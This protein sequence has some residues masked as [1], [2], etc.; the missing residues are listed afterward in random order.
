MPVDSAKT[1]SPSNGVCA[2]R[3]ARAS[4]SCAMIAQAAAAALVERGV[5]GDHCNRR[6]GAGRRRRRSRNSLPGRAEHRGPPAAAS[7]SP[8]SARSAAQKRPQSG[9][10]VAPQLLTATIA[11]TVCA[12]GEAQR[13]AADAALEPARRGAE[14]R[15]GIAQREILGRRARRRAAEAR[16]RAARR[17]SGRRPGKPRSNRIAAGTIGTTIGG[18]PG[19]VDPEPAARLGEPVH[20]TAGGVEAKGRAAGQHDR[21]DPVD[22]GLRG[23]QFGLAAARR[24]AAHIDRGRPPS[25]SAST[26]VV[27]VMPS[28]SSACPTR[29]PGTSVIRL[30]GPVAAI[31]LSPAAL[32]GC[33]IGS[34]K[35]RSN[36][37]L[38]R[39]LI[40]N[41]DGIEAPGLAVLERIAGELAPRSGWW[42]RSTTRA[43]C[44]TPS[45]CITRS[46]SPSGALAA[47]GSPAPRE[48]ARSSEWRI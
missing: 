18:E 4:P 44:R 22:Q 8:A 14:P 48:I 3:I 10:T 46:G 29:I 12:A 45:A 39:I 2:G 27:P 1:V 34:P 20:H 28:R 47:T 31:R 38:D 25:R 43:G 24:A 42:R 6:V 26:T 35:N 19:P 15:P 11:P 13:R 16:E 32:L 30:R 40:T 21:I 7:I 17:S 9:R 5:G 37:V 36:T 23:E 33:R 41:D